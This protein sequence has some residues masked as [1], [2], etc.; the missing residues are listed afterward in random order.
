MRTFAVTKINDRGHPQSGGQV[1]LNL[2]DKSEDRVSHHKINSLFSNLGDFGIPLDYRYYVFWT[3]GFS[4]RPTGRYFVRYGSKRLLG[5]NPLFH[6]LVRMKMFTLD[7]QRR[8]DGSGV[9]VS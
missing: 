1:A 3:R 9:S 4:V 6:I 7:C 8:F 5:F 2:P